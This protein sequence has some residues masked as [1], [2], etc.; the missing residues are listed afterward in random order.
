MIAKNH[1]Y[2]KGGNL[3]PQNIFQSLACVNTS[4]C[5]TLF[6]AHIFTQKSNSL[7]SSSYI[8]DEDLGKWHIATSFHLLHFLSALYFHFFPIQKTPIY[9]LKFN[10][11]SWKDFHYILRDNHLFSHIIGILAHGN[12][13]IVVLL[14]YVLFMT[15]IFGIFNKQM[16]LHIFKRNVKYTGYIRNFIQLLVS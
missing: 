11:A 10:W 4:K 7:L 2:N 1:H 13:L 9:P 15:V 12:F 6:Q 3:P 14:M 16:C 8:K 5:R